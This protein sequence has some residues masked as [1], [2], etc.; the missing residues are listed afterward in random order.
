MDPYAVSHF[1][2]RALLHDLK[3][4]LAQDRKLTAVL[5]TRIAEVD[6]RQLFRKEGYSSM[7]E[8]CLRELHFSEGA[9]YKRINAARAVRDFPAVLVAVVE[10]R[11]HLSG[12]VTLAAHLT[13]GNVDELVAA[14]THKTRA[15][16]EQLIAERF[17]RP[18]WPERLQAIPVSLSPTPLEHDQLSP[19]NVDAST[20]SPEQPADNPTH[21]LPQGNVA[22][23]A[24]RP[25][26]TPL[27]PE[28][29]GLQ[30]TLDRETYDLLEYNRSLMSHQNPGGEIVPVLYSALKL[31]AAHLEKQKFA[32]TAHPRPA[33]PSGSARYIPAAVKRAVRE[34]DGG[35]C[36]F[37]SDSGRRCASRRMLETIWN[38]GLAVVRSCHLREERPTPVARSHPR[39]RV[40]ASGARAAYERSPSWARRVSPS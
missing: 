24:P 11:L 31:L 27:A 9:A 20:I 26:L 1:S 7:R 13:P 22:A 39:S 14:A 21:M 30:V 15:E 19:G 38:D 5:L 23:P 25:R 10:G 18:D 17:P 16:I 28:R 29:F 12:V 4:L 8:Y 32:A 35:R 6:E 3:S 2:D 37:V 34:R 40:S 36:T 33:K